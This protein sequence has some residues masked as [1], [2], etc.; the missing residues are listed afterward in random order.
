M[1]FR[2]IEL[3]GLVIGLLIASPALPCSITEPIPGAA[4]LISKAEA[5]VLVRAEGLSAT[6]GIDGLMAGSRTQVRF[7]VLGVLK[8]MLAVPVIE[9][10]GVL[11]GHDDPND[12][13]APYNFVR[14]GGRHGNCF[15]LEYRAGAEYLLLLNRA[16]HQAYAQRNQLT[17]YWSPLAPTNEQVFGDADRWLQWVEAQ[18]AK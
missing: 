8:G 6:P 16:D 18:L 2:G 11:E 10:N 13:P 1:T 17:P 4:T 12:R 3:P 15:A 14:P 7:A 5:I 9:F